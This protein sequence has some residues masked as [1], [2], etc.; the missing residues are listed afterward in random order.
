MYI[1]FFQYLPNFSKTLAICVDGTDYITFVKKILSS[2]FLLFHHL[3]RSN[4]T[5][6]HFSLKQYNMLIII[7]M[8]IA[9]IHFLF[10]KRSCSIL[11]K[12]LKNKDR[13]S[14]ESTRDPQ[15]NTQEGGNRGNW[16][17][18]IMITIAPLRK[19]NCLHIVFFMFD[20]FFSFFSDVK[21]NFNLITFGKDPTSFHH[22]IIILIS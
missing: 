17:E 12:V 1:I 22:H 2:I 13:E 14:K 21:N 8:I 4:S 3:L 16:I 20:G 15:N 9:T 11:R 6:S 18:I 19:S 5:I 7:F 10:K